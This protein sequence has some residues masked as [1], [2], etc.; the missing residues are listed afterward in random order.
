MRTKPN[1]GNRLKN[2]IKPI[3]VLFLA[4]TL[5][6]TSNCI[7]YEYYMGASIP[8]ARLSQVED[9]TFTINSSYDAEHTLTNF[10][11]TFNV[12]ATVTHVMV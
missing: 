9:T 10:E 1:Q 7:I 5:A 3:Y 6:S 4:L 11:T 8:P 12:D 2:R